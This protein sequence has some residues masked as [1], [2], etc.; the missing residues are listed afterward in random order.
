MT[1]IPASAIRI[2]A[3]VI[4]GALIAGFMFVAANQGID[5]DLTALDEAEN[6]NEVIGY[7][8]YSRYN[9]ETVTGAE[10]VKSRKSRLSSKG[11]AR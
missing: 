7:D 2:I 5:M 9:G 4:I 8:K 1:Y 11:S 10:I 3:A 6:V